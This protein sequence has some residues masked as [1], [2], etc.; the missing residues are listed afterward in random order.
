M[1]R[2]NRLIELARLLTGRDADID[3]ALR[4]ELLLHLDRGDW[5]EADSVTTRERLPARLRWLL[6]DAGDDDSDD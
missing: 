3:P 6:R 2:I 1:D 4:D 5:T